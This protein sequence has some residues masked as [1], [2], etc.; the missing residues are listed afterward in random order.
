VNRNG[1]PSQ[2]MPDLPQPVS[3]DRQNSQ[4]QTRPGRRDPPIQ[5]DLLVAGA[6]VTILSARVSALRPDWSLGEMI[7]WLA[8]DYPHFVHSL[9]VC[10]ID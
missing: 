2:S 8:A 10:T 4:D 5:A 9:I 7:E 6:F 1:A 3:W